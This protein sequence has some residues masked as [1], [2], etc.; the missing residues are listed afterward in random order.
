[1]TW[2]DSTTL[3]FDWSGKFMSTS[4]L[5]FELSLGTTM[6]SGILQKWV[7]LGTDHTHHTVSDS[8]LSQTQDYFLSVVA[9][10]A[11]GLHT[12]A[13]LTESGFP[14]NP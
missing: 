3:H 4:P 11:S 13:S 12:T 2:I 7:E 9:I 6:G 10:S 1:M 14:L 8:R 5:T